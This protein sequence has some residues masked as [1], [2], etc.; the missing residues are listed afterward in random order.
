MHN[1]VNDYIVLSIT[2]NKSNILYAEVNNKKQEKM[3]FIY[4]EEDIFSLGENKIVSRG[5]K[6]K[7]DE[8][9]MIIMTNIV[10]LSGRFFAFFNKSINK[11]V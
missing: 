5:E 4:I 3:S 2:E 1:Y 10:H 8:Y 6:K 9:T 7:K 11:R